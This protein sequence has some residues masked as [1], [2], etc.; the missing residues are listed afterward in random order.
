M[1]GEI[2]IG[3]VKAINQ[4]NGGAS[5]NDVLSEMIWDGAEEADV[6]EEVFTRNQRKYNDLVL[7]DRIEDEVL[8][9]AAQQIYEG[10]RT[11]IQTFFFKS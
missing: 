5:F 6:I 1:T 7:A 4:Q 8:K 3:F 11:N 9:E 10:S 2:I